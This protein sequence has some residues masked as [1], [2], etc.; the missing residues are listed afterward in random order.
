[1]EGRVG[2]ASD[3]GIAIEVD[4]ESSEEEPESGTGSELNVLIAKLASDI[5]KL[6]G[7]NSSVVGFSDHIVEVTQ[8]D[9]VESEGESR[10]L[11]AESA[12][13]EAVDRGVDATLVDGV[14]GKRQA[15]SSHSGVWAGADD[16][17][18]RGNSS[19]R[20]DEKREG[21]SK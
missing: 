3:K 14:A 8:T 11:E 21:D 18:S 17:V 1:L 7:I 4:G 15:G 16:S 19:G 2:K 12:R 10:E 20:N 6:G 13:G 9:S 5:G